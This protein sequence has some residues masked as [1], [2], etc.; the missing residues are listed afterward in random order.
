MPSLTM[1]LARA[2]VLALALAALLAVLA[3]AR[4][5]AQVDPAGCTDEVALRPDDPD[6]RG[7][8]RSPAG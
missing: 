7:R 5:L 4:A 6:L 8:G 3:P 1:P 2:A